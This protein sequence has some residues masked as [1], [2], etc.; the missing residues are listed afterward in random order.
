MT[1]SGV[2]ATREVSPRFRYLY[3]E[4]ARQKIVENYVCAF[5]LLEHCRQINPDAPE[6]LYELSLYHRLLHNDSL[7]VSYL[8]RAVELDSAQPQYIEALA[9][10]RLEQH[11]VDRAL[12][13]IETMARLQPR[14]TDVL[15][16][17]VN[18]YAE[19]GR[20][21][22]AIRALDRIELLEGMMPSVSYRKFA[23]YKQM[24]KD[25]EAYATLEALCREYPHEVS[26]R[27]AIANELVDDGRMDEAQAIFDEVRKQEPGNMALRLSQMRY[28]RDSD[29]DSLFASS[30]DAL[31][32]DRATPSDMRIAIMRDL[33]AEQMKDEARGRHVVDSVFARLDTVKAEDVDMLTLRAAFLVTYD[34][35][36][37]SLFVEVMDRINS[38][39]P[40]N[41]QALFYLIQ[42][43]GQHQLYTQ[44]EAICRRG[45]I[46][47]PEELICH[48]FL[49]VALFQQDKREE[50][51]QAFRSGLRQRT[52][53]SKATMVA[54]LYSIMGD[55]LH[56]LGHT[57]EAYEAYDSC[58]VYQDD[59][60]ACLNN[61]AYYL[62]LEE[63]DLDHAE[64]MSY[65]TIRLHPD[66][67]TY[68]DTY[69]WIL[70]QKARYS[71][72]ARY[73]DRVCPA[74]SADSVL[75]ADAEL[76]AVVFEHAGDIAA[77]NGQLER[78]LRFWRLAQQMGGK[79][80]TPMLPKKIKLKKYVK[81]GSNNSQL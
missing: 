13:L 36:N 30:R 3:A 59:N 15:S 60:V 27:L 6:V 42:Y 64:E 76:S 34:K 43:Y 51:L 7:A 19:A 49:G 68:L 52:E 70:F 37:D 22:D 20:P 41:T 11:D 39:Q 25:A 21:A 63:R 69:A 74:D 75:L 2:K 56:D 45:V 58:L 1:S 57:A 4:A 29:Q 62:S 48:Y 10:L 54:D 18:L 79:G 81:G 33:I 5:D 78:A 66:N 16:R 44:L 26:Y 8:E 32:Y 53:Q 67:K 9:A 12:P 23:L 61:Y 38:I 55:V 71:E 17:L 40:S 80:V 73:I 72:A 35:D 28:Y 14:R 31:L 46:T 24:D 47:H 77:M 65:R 50:A